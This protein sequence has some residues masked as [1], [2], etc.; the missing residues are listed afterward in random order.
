M[1]YCGGCHSLKYMRYARIAEDLGLT[2]EDVMA[3]LNFT[4][5]KIGDHV[6][7][8][9]TA[10]NGR[11]RVRQGAAGPEPGRPRARPATGSTPT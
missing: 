9:M 3:N 6:I 1:N 10:G 5:A 11:G 8:A 2:E 4:G 7:S